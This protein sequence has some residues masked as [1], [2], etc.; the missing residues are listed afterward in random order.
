MSELFYF[1][2]SSL[3][4]FVFVMLVTKNFFVFWL[5]MTID[6]VRLFASLDRILK[7]KLTTL[8]EELVEVDEKRFD[9]VFAEESKSVFSEG[10]Q[11]GKQE[12]ENADFCLF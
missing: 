9:F 3:N 7:R 11:I 5:L 8:Q 10:K 2:L 6:D 12:Q 4:A 1:L